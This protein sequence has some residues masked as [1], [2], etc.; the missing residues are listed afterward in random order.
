L[1]STPEKP[2]WWENMPV[3]AAATRKASSKWCCCP[4][5]PPSNEVKCEP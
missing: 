4:N 5:L 3:G 2:P 1:P